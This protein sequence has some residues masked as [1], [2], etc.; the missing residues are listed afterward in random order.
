MHSDNV[1]KCK[2][3]QNVDEHNIEVHSTVECVL[4]RR[5][6]LRSIA[7]E[8]E[9]TVLWL[10]IRSVSCIRLLG[11]RVTELV[12]LVVSE[13]LLL[14][15]LLLLQSHVL[16]LHGLA[17]PLLQVEINRLADHEAFAA[18]SNANII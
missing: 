17:F 8:H 5:E 7:H 10:K 18:A 16:H 9:R 13:G 1:I 6:G 4:E 11:L 3:E 2:E 15:L 12:S 14:H